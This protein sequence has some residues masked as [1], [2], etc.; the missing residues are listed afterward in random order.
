MDLQP[1][2]SQDYRDR[3][4]A[5]GHW[6]DLTLT[7]CLDRA[8]AKHP[9]KVAIRDVNSMTEQQT[10]LTFAELADR[11]RLVALG[12]HRLGV[13]RGDVVSYQLPNW[14]EFAALHLACLRI[15]AVTNPLM[16][17][18][19]E[20]ELKFMLG[21][22][23][24]KVFVV[25]RIFR[26][27]DF[28]AMAADL[29]RALPSLEHV[30]VVGGEG[31]SS[32]EAALLDPA[33]PG[34][35][36]ALF[37]ANKPGPDDIVELVY[38]SG[39]TGE[40]K[41]AMQ[42][43]NVMFSN[44]VAYAERAGLTGDDVLFM[45]SPMAHQTGFLYGFMMGI[46]L[47]ATT[48]YQD[49]WNP[50]LAADLIE[51]EGVNFTM[52]STPF[53]ADLTD[54]AEKRPEAMKSLRVF[55]AGGAPIPR[56]LVRRSIE[57]LGAKVLS[58]WGMTENGAVTVTPLDA[59]EEKVFE[60][61]GLPLS[62]VTLRILDAEG[63]VLPTGEEGRLQAQ[64]CSMFAGYY[65][66]AHLNGIDEDNWFETGDLARLDADG[67]VRITGRSKDIII[68]G[69]ENVPVV[70]VENLLFKHPDVQ[71][72]AI[73]G[74]PDER[75]G[76]RACAFVVTKEAKP[77]TLADVV[78]FLQEQKLSRNYLPE[79]VEVLPAFPRTP[80]GKIQKFKLREMAASLKD[81]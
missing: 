42:T 76:E 8:V 1:F 9:D 31:A 71:E 80:S 10:T 81:V 5:G 64:A 75:L 53:L 7:E 13:R 21:L 49:V 34:D 72:V 36:D 11:V 47:G 57:K 27:F 51:A 17:I 70:E 60:T 67:Y 40:P 44:I 16:P 2:F 54:M 77:M 3:M 20:H 69:G 4:R 74:M 45:A 25:P 14:W 73:V 48:V 65:K 24:A 19:R 15:G 46:Y 35:A 43:S 28:P 79:R 26:G 62:G 6:P 66:R 29:Q 55:V 50:A 78:A 56:A 68:R 30:L 63:N 38:T 39:T 32:F 52:G 37:A 23:E 18:F 22:A 58:G 59:P 61:D 41:G 12:L 33:M